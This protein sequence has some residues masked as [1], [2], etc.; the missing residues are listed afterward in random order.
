MKWK[1][2]KKYLKIGLLALGVIVL[3]I[4]FQYMLEHGTEVQ[5]FKT[6]VKQTMM[7]IVFGFILA[8]LL[9]P[10]LKFFERCFLHRWQGSFG[11]RK[12]RRKPEINFQGHLVFFVP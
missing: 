4:L 11:E 2:E 12:S 1:I 9:N 10:I 8:Y 5:Q 3:A 7:P 6:L